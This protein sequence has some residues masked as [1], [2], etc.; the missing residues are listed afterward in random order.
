MVNNNYKNALVFLFLTSTL[1]I[2]A[3]Y[4]SQYIFGLEPCILCL[5][6]RQPFF[7]IIA[8][9]S[10]ALVFF[11]KIKTQKNLVL[12]SL[13]LL[14]VNCLIAFYHSAVEKKLVQGPTTCSSDSLND[15]N[16]IEDLKNA[17]LTAKAVRC[18]EPEFFF[19]NLTMANWNFIYCLILI[20]ITSKIAFKKKKVI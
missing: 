18:D 19:L 4:I 17:L 13:F 9:S 5:Y 3:A 2:V 11:K 6:Q 12:L 15:F 10:F 7:A 14:F 16:N 1:A 8:L 20:I